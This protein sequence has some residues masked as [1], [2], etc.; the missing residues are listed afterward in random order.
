MTIFSGQSE[1][2]RHVLVTVRLDG[3]S[4]EVVLKKY[5]VPG[6]VPSGKPP[7]SEPYRTVPYHAVE[8]RHNIHWVLTAG[9]EFSIAHLW[10]FIVKN[11][12]KRLLNLLGLHCTI[13][14][15]SGPS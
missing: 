9:W 3:T 10:H 5:Q 1:F 7:K 2:T 15:R 6:T 13:S 4:T 8:K 12:M 14:E 11:D